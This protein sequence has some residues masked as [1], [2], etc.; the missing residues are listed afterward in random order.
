MVQRPNCIVKPP[1]SLYVVKK[2]E[3]Q[4][5][6][7]RDAS[8][9]RGALK[10]K[11]AGKTVKLCGPQITKYWQAM[12]KVIPYSQKFHQAQVS[13]YILNFHQYGKGRH[14]LYVIINTG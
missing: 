11:N 12:T 2:V 4:L 9:P 13:L 3:K 5:L 8:T 10:V 7:I 1:L 6:M 14:M